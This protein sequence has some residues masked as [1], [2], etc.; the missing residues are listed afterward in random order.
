MTQIRAQATPRINLLKPAKMAPVKQHPL[1][2]SNAAL[3]K[4]KPFNVLNPY[5][6]LN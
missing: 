2:G 5:V 3:P 4:E 1:F 6:N